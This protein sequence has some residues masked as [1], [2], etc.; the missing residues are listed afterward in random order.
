[1]ILCRQ[2]VEAWRN[3]LPQT[4]QTNGLAPER[5]NEKDL[6]IYDYRLILT[7][8]VNDKWITDKFTYL[9]AQAYVGSSCNEH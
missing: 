6:P 9:C 1:M 7:T 5:K 8:F 3:P 2:R 4:L